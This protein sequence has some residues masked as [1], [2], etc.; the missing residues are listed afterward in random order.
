M[1]NV[2]PYIILFVAKYSIIILPISQATLSRGKIVTANC[3]TYQQILTSLT[4]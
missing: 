2:Y 4:E 3:L 1:V